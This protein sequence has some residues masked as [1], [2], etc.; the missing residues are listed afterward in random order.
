[1]GIGNTSTQPVFVYGH[2]S[3]VLSLGLNLEHV[4]GTEHRK[5]SCSLVRCVLVGHRWPRPVLEPILLRVSAGHLPG[6]RWAGSVVWR[7]LPRTALSPERDGY[8]L[9]QA[10]RCSRCLFRG[11]DGP[12]FG[13]A[14]ELGHE[15]FVAVLRPSHGTGFVRVAVSRGNTELFG[16]AYVCQ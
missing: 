9:P 1:M 14:G 7:G 4:R 12:A 16:L 15:V 13:V 10:G 8:V 3:A 11:G 6:F 5:V 2:D